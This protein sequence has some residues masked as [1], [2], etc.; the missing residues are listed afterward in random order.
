M[1]KKTVGRI[2]SLKETES[3]GICAF[4][5]DHQRLFFINPQSYQLIK[6]IEYD[7]NFVFMSKEIVKPS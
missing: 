3:T 6:I 1:K 4:I 5:I 2:N 7:F